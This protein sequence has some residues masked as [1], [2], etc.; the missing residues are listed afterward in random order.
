MIARLA[1]TVEDLAEDSAIV[2]VHGVGYRVYIDQRTRAELEPGTPV[3]L[4]VHTQVRE[5]AITLYGFT[6]AS[7]RGVFEKLI[8]VNKVGPKLALAALG[9]MDPA[10]LVHAIDTD[11]VAA[12]TRIKGIGATVAR[13]ITLDLK[14][15]LTGSVDFSPTRPVAAAGPSDQFVLAL[16]RLGYKRTEIATALSGL[17]AQGLTEAPVPERLSAALRIL[18]RT[19]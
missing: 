1:G 12:L 5:D 9:G 11:D 15:K 8:G 13:R 10:A 4:H 14:G 17:K 3:V 16:A 18:S 6:T 2:D 7:A 19:E